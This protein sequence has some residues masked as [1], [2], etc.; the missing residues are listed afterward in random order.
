MLWWPGPSGPRLVPAD[1]IRNMIACLPL[2]LR[3]WRAIQRGDVL[4]IWLDGADSD[5]RPALEQA[6]ADLGRR[7]NCT[8]PRLLVR[9]GLPSEGDA[10]RRRVRVDAG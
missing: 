8:P 5:P 9:A 6:L 10:K 7:L 2:R 1:A 4:E 3:D